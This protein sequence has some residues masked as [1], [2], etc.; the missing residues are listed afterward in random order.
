MSEKDSA[1][2]LNHVQ[3]AVKEVLV[4]FSA[5][6]INENDILKAL[7][8]QICQ[9]TDHPLVRLIGRNNDGNGGKGTA[10]CSGRFRDLF[11]CVI[12]YAFSIIHVFCISFCDTIRLLS[13]TVVNSLSVKLSGFCLSLW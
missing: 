8:L 1:R 12:V 2:A 6:V 3:G 4:V 7:L 13:S 9:E 11:F 5:P 10:C